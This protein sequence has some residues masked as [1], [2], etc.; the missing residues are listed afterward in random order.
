MEQSEIKLNIIDDEIIRKIGNTIYDNTPNTPDWSTPFFSLYT[1]FIKPNFLFVLWLVVVSGFLIYMYLNKKHK[2]K[3][4]S[5]VTKKQPKPKV[6]PDESF[7]L[8]ENDNIS[9][10]E[11][12]MD[13]IEIPEDLD[14]NRNSTK[15]LSALHDKM[16]PD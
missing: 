14:I 1:N 15:V 6:I 13:D 11:S 3:K 9:K 5:V 7:K 10:E 2:T 12:L 16:F 8:I 4:K